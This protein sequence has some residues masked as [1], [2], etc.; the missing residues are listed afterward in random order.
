[1]ITK[2]IIDFANDLANISGQVSKKYF[3]QK[4]GSEKKADNSPVTIADQEIEQLL[5]AKIKN[6]FPKHGVIG[7]EFGE[8]NP[9]SDF[10]WVI[11]PI[12]GTK[13]FM[14][15][16]PTFTNLIALCYKKKPILGIINQPILCERW[17]GYDGKA[18]LNNQRIYSRKCLNFSQAEIATTSLTYFSQEKARFLQKIQDKTKFNNN[19]LYGGDAYLFAMLA[20][21]N[22]DIIIESE[23]KKYDIM[24]LVPII[25]GSGGKIINW[26]HNE[27]DL[28]SQGDV[29]AFGD[30]NLIKLIH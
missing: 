7:E 26:N 8:I 19:H 9:N 21:G 30:Q 13:A 22:I 12:D 5:R 23:L 28:L 20:S 3:R 15:G 2:E 25:E 29:I 1:M 11:D 18:F 10:I 16:I 17:V 14:A 6:H 27:V 4:I 24:A